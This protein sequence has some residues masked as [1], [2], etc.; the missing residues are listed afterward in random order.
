VIRR[1][2]IIGLGGTGSSICSAVA[3][4]LVWEHGSLVR[5]PFVDFL[6][7]DTAE[8][9]ISGV[10]RD[11][12]YF[13]HL[14]VDEET[15]ERMRTNVEAFSA[16][17]QLPRWIDRALLQTMGVVRTGTQGFRMLGRLSMLLPENFE[18]LQTALQNKL[19]RLVLLKSG[20]AS[21]AFGSAVEFHR[22]TKVF[23][24]GTTA[25]GTGSGTYVDMGYLLRGWQKQYGNV[26]TVG[27]L[28]LPSADEKDTQK[29][30]NTYA[31]LTELNHFSTDGNV[32]SVKY[33]DP[34]HPQPTEIH[35]YPFDL[36]YLVTVDVARASIGGLRDFAELKRTV[37]QYIH[38]ESMTR[39]GEVADGRRNDISRFFSLPDIK[40]NSQRYMTFGISFLEYPVDRVVKG[41]SARLLTQA[42]GGWLK[43]VSA[44]SIQGVVE[45][46]GLDNRAITGSL[47]D[48]MKA[49]GQAIINEALRTYHSARDFDETLRILAAGFRPPSGEPGPPAFPAGGVPRRIEER[50]SAVTDLLISRI[51]GALPGDADPQSL[52]AILRALSAHLVSLRVEAPVPTDDAVRETLGFLREVEAD[53]VIRFS[54]M[55]RSQG[56]T[57]FARQAADDLTDLLA[58][59]LDRAASAARLEI[60]GRAGEEVDRWTRRADA[61]CRYVTALH[62]AFD[63][64]WE[65]QDRG[66]EINGVLLFRSGSRSNDPNVYEAAT[67]HQDFTRLL[68][69]SP[70]VEG[71]ADAE[72]AAEALAR[73]R[74][75]GRLLAEDSLF[76]D[77][78]RSYL[79]GPGGAVREVDLAGCL[80]D[81]SGFFRHGR[82]RGDIPSAFASAFPRPDERIAQVERLKALADCFLGVTPNDADPQNVV[83][84]SNAWA[85]FE[86]ARTEGEFKELL[87]GRLGMEWTFEE[88][89]EAHLAVLLRERGAFPLRLVRG[90]DAWR[91][92]YEAELARPHGNVLH[93]RRDVDWLPIDE[94]DRE[95]LERA[96]ELFL[97]G[98]GLELIRRNGEVSAW[99]YEPETQDR[100]VRPLTL[101]DSVDASARRLRENLRTMDMLDAQIHRFTRS[102]DDEDAVIKRLYEDLLGRVGV[103]G[104]SGL[105]PDPRRGAERILNGFIL[106]EPGLYEAYRRV[107][108]PEPMLRERL[109]REIGAPLSNGA[110]APLAGY[111]CDA[112]NRWFGDGAEA[113]PA[114]CACGRMFG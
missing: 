44:P 66:L 43:P 87:R 24:V 39:M 71:Q 19:S 63:R 40:G 74:V 21:E 106:K 22:T 61:L 15:V 82:H 114:R 67:L 38:A 105:G 12:R 51:R 96:R 33:P 35:D 45:A 7:I 42:L 27:I 46:A 81:V 97:V 70:E 93:A 25:G 113:V 9:Q 108:P 29:T 47:V 94:Q 30:A 78:N 103:L 95:R 37:G 18:R 56:R 50:K 109:L 102:R 57:Y 73:R 3:E 58:A 79:D 4:R 55:L 64:L 90:I 11:S 72:K 53:F 83:R 89:D 6:C 17:M 2:L 41:S 100:E 98:I 88:L 75:M 26:E 14:T 69:A 8:D 111:Y 76:A 48:D 107:Y 62:A 84:K 28:T 16:S 54:M 49:A 32:Y 112:C 34:L 101:N 104:L 65:E 110:P 86:G 91:A 80:Q 36:S 23:V 13:H 52:A 68:K 31:L 92:H 1:T 60:L 99:R 20:D 59:Q 85:M 10:L 5:L 77:P